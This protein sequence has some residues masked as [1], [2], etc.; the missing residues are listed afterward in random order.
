MTILIVSILNDSLPCT[1]IAY[2]EQ[3]HP[4]SKDNKSIYEHDRT[5]TNYFELIKQV[6][7][8]Y[9]KE[10][11]EHLDFNDNIIKIDKIITN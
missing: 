8:D 11:Y 4:T 9:K 2:M 3:I 7:F 6:S 1:Y 5:L 10:L